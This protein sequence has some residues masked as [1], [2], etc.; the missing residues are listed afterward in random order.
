MASAIIPGVED[1]WNA[2]SSASD[3]SWRGETIF[4]V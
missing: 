2:I 1:K 3:L 4:F